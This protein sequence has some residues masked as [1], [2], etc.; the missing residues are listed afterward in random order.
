MVASQLR[1][2]IQRSGAGCVKVQE[3]EVRPLLTND[4]Q[5]YVRIL[6]NHHITANLSKRVRENSRLIGIANHQQELHCVACPM[7]IAGASGAPS[8]R[9]STT[10]LPSIAMNVAG[11]VLSEGYAARYS[12]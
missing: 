9:M 3:H 7:T 2:E 6:R 11:R 1:Q 4:A 8:S 5:A 10:A 12:R